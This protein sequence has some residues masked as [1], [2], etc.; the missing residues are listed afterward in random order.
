M[1]PLPRC[2]A[3]RLCPRLLLS[4][5]LTPRP[6]RASPPP[7]PPASSIRALRSLVKSTR[8]HHGSRERSLSTAASGLW[9]RNHVILLLSLLSCA[10]C[11]CNSAA[12]TLRR[13]RKTPS[14]RRH[15]SSLATSVALSRLSR[16]STSA[17]PSLYRMMDSLLQIKMDL[18]LRASLK[19][20]AECSIG[21]RTLSPGSMGDSRL[22]LLS[23]RKRSTAPSSELATW[24]SAS[25]TIR[26]LS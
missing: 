24:T 6:S 15:T 11:Y 8:G 2:L 12:Q 20:S 17:S 9:S 1:R 13:K 3:L 19:T 5:R 25:W 14:S 16:S 23:V 22:H 18:L 7:R 10:R 26:I 4:P 21:R